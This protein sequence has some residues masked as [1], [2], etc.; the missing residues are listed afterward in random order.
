[1]FVLYCEGLRYL[2]PRPSLVS[3]HVA[4]LHTKFNA[5]VSIYQKDKYLGDKVAMK[6]FIYTAFPISPIKQ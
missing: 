2:V 1:M 5:P 4:H 6:H 3:Q